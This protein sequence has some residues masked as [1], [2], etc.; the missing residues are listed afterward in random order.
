MVKITLTGCAQAVGV[1]A[2]AKHYIGTEQETHRTNSEINGV[3]VT[4]IS[5]NIDD[6]SLHELYLW[7]FA[8]ADKAGVK[9]ILRDELGFQEYVMSDWLGKFLRIP[10]TSP[11]FHLYS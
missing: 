6:R 1:Q 8:N 4:G 7:L 5:A 9:G 10:N 2:C 3:D 11:D